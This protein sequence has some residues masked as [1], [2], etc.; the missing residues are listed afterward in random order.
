MHILINITS[1]GTL[2]GQTLT[3]TAFGVTLLRMSNRWQKSLLWFCIVTMN[4]WMLIK[5][6]FQWAKYCDK[7]NYQQWYRIPGICIN[8]SFE[9]SFKE[10]GNSEFRTARR[11][12]DWLLIMLVS[13]QHHNGL[14]V[15]SYS[16]VDHMAI[17]DAENRKDRSLRYDE[18][19][20]DV[21]SHLTRIEIS[22]LLKHVLTVNSIA[23]FSAIRTSWEYTNIQHTHDAYYYCGSKFPHVHLLATDNPLQGATACQWYGTQP[24]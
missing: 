19:G 7:G 10:G 12:Y 20:N 24:K 17:G 14:C 13:L 4:V 15:C 2:L 21:C 6:L 23:I 9:E 22:S 16:V 3:K 5:V 1:C 8:Y 11:N 18:F